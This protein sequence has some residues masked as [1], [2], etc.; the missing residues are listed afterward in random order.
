VPDNR[1][2]P[3][4]SFIKTSALAAGALALPRVS[5]AQPGASPN[6][7]FGTRRRQAVG[8]LRG[9]AGGPGEIRGHDVTTRGRK[10]YAAHP[11]VPRFG[12]PVML[13]LHQQIDAVL[14]STPDH[15]HFGSRWRPWS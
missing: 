6:G 9:R 1:E 12:L 15:T 8:R 2:S 3:R 4:R 7:S 11:E 5:I 10:A 14:I 13:T